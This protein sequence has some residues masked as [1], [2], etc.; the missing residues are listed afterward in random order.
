M[1]DPRMN[2][3]DGSFDFAPEH[4]AIAA[5]ISGSNMITRDPLG[6]EG[7]EREKEISSIVSESESE[8]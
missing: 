6:S 4:P 1:T 8:S 3:K 5:A 2:K 7:L